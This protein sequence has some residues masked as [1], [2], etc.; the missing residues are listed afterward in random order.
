MSQI[1]KISII[2]GTRPQIIKTQPLIHQLLKKKFDVEIIHTG[3]HYDFKLSKIFFKDLDIPKASKNL[4]INK[5]TQLQQISKII[6][7]LEK[8]LKKSR[9]DLVIIP[10]DTTSA[11]AGALSASKLKIKLAHLEAGARSNQLYM[12]EEINRRIIDHCSDILF[13]PTKN[14]L[15]NLRNESV[16][17]KTY[18]VGDTMLDL[19][20]TWKK[21]N[22]L[23]HKT[24]KNKTILF[25][26]HRAENIENPKNLKKISTIV[27]KLSKDHKIIFPIHPHTKKKIEENNLKF[28]T[29]KISPLDYSSLMNLINEVDAI[30]TDSGGLQ[31]EAFWMNR[32]CITLRESTEW[33]ETTK[34]GA[35][36][37]APLSRPF[38]FSRV[39]KLLNKKIKT[40]N[41]SFGNGK[42]SEA[43][44][45]IIKNL[46]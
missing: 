24:S 14:C 3:Q 19:L 42:A 20:L 39:K 41:N 12:S 31:K 6:G 2:I 32:P 46:H 22:K 17:G 27:N 25:T 11:I 44:T 28:N 35:N 16:F 40:R 5:G 36:L 30:I 37:L 45:K 18:F 23:K 43:I 10:G 21:K 13:A 15:Q 9:P 29:K 34:S 7:L 1:K 38:P 4:K 26:L 8:H 33:I